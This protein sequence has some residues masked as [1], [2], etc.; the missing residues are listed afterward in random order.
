MF[1]GLETG[2]SIVKRIPLD[3]TGTHFF[4]NVCMALGP[5]LIFTV[6]TTASKKPPLKTAVHKTHKVAPGC[7][8]GGVNRCRSH[9]R[10]AKF[11]GSMIG[12][13]YSDVIG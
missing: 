3:C 6:F 12:V 8:M 13:K 1:E 4:Q 7:F 10:L 5:V 2:T 11:G 9:C